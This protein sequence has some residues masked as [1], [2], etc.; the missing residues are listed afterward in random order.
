[1][2]HRLI[3][4]PTDADTRADSAKVGAI[5]YDAV[6]DRLGVINASQE[7]QVRDDDANTSLESIDTKLSSGITVTATDLDIRNLVFADDKVDVS[8]SE[9]SLDAATLAALETVTV[10]QGTSPWVVSATDLDIR[11]LSASTD[12]VSISDGTDTL[13]VNAD[14]SINVAITDATG[15]TID[16]SDVYAEDSAHTTGD[17]G[18][19]ILAIRN[20]TLGSLVDTD[21]DYTGLQVNASGELYVKDTDVLA[22]LQG[23]IDVTTNDVTLAN[24]AIKQVAETVSTTAAVVVDGADELS[25]RKYFWAYNNDNRAVYLGDSSVSAANGYPIF[26]GSEFHARIGD[27]VDIYMIGEKLSTDVRTLQTS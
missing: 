8:G 3:F 9:V 23:G 26:P 20:D 5:L 13:G 19:F 16:E 18:S 6:N 11:D 12:S 14:G 1:M 17:N 25:S 4:D 24:S 2:L 22:E 7:L 21:G 15:I 10:E 27:A